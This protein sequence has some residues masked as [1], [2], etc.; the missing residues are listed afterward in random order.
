V[1]FLQVLKGK[2]G[3]LLEDNSNEFRILLSD[4]LTHGA[5]LKVLSMTGQK[6]MKL[7]KVSSFCPIMK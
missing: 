4:V 7:L 5:D 1:H 2:E 3:L 6:I